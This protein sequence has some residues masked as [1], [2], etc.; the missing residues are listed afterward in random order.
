M[1]K[2]ILFTYICLSVF[3]IVTFSQAITVTDLST[4]GHFDP[5]NP[6]GG[7]G[8]NA[9]QPIVTATFVGGP[10]TSVVGGVITVPILAIQRGFELHFLT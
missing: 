8:C 7:G 4:T 9:G 5:L 1:F 3:T 2:K 6:L 10:G